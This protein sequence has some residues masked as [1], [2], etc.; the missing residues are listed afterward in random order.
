MVS[1]KSYNKD[2]V[3]KHKFSGRRI[4]RGLYKAGDDTLINSDVN[5]AYNI[6]RKL[7]PNKIDNNISYQN[8]H[9]QIINMN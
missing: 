6:I 7:F 4:K 2:K 5:G 3:D 1:W 9:P 8:M